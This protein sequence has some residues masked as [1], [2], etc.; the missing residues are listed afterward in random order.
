M[1]LQVE[2]GDIKLFLLLDDV[3]S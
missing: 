2:K 3:I 1:K